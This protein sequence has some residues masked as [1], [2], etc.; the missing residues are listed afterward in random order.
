MNGYYGM[1]MGG[2]FANGNDAGAIN[3]I[4]TSVFDDNTITQ[5]AS[6]AF[7]SVVSTSD[8]KIVSVTVNTTAKESIPAGVRLHIMVTEKV[9]EWAKTWPAGVDDATGLT[10]NGQKIMYDVIW[11]I[12]GDTLGNDFP[13]LSAGESHS[14][15]HDFTLFGDKNQNPDNMEVTAILQVDATKEIIGIARMAGSPYSSDNNPISSKGILN[16]MNG[17]S[18]NVMGNK[19]S[20]KLPF[21]K[22]EVS[23]F[24]T[25]GRM[26]KMQNLNGNKGS[27]VSLNLPET[28][29]VFL[30]KLKSLKGE[31]FTQS[32]I[33]K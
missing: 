33:L 8:D 24:N 23:F 14:M 18:L 10:G 27:M 3:F 29:G 22:T 7:S 16:K 11:D 21:N 2:A 12:I 20:F 19:L 1:P 17:L 32:L 28:K 5:K 9:I 31:V 25:A 13:V 4:Q 26:L 15:T 30:M 6:F